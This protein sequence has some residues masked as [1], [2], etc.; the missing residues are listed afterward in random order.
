MSRLSCSCFIIHVFVLSYAKEYEYQVSCFVFKVMR[1]M[2]H[3]NLTFGG[4]TYLHRVGL[5]SR[6]SW[7]QQA[8]ELTTG[9]GGFHF[10]VR[11]CSTR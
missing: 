7:G 11:Q 2:V 4:L 9:K 8:Q 5:E 6:I 10:L 1:G 3:S